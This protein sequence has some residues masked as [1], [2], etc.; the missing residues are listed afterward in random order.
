MLNHQNDCTQ[1]GLAYT[2]SF[3]PLCRAQE[4]PDHRGGP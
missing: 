4:A 3:L 2:L 1:V